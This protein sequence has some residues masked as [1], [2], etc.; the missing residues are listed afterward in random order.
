[1]FAL[2]LTEPWILETKLTFLPPGGERSS[3]QRI[4]VPGPGVWQF[5]LGPP[6]C[7]S[8]GRMRKRAKVH[9]EIH[10]RKLQL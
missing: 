5:C 3:L 1:M 7:S 8:S 4:S 9:S 2:R 10:D 6:R